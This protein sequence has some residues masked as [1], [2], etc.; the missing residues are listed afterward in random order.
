MNKKNSKYIIGLTLI[1]ILIGIVI[2]SIM[3]A[4][5]YTSYNV[6]NQSYS[7]VAEKAKISKASGSPESKQTSSRDKQASQSIQHSDINWA[8][9][10]DPETGEESPVIDFYECYARKKVAM[11]NAYIKNPPFFRGIFFRKVILGLVFNLL[12]SLTLI[13]FSIGG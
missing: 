6:V 1:E 8:D 3:M 7:K 11:V 12:F 5:M 4:A 2:T 9:L 10:Y 13:F